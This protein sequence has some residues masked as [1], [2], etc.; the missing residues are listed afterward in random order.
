MAK[1]FTNL[2]TANAVDTAKAIAGGHVSALEVCDAAIDRIEQRNDAV[3]A[4]I[5]QDF[6][7]ARENAKMLDKTRDAG[8]QRPLLGVPMT[9]KESIDVEGLP[10]SWGFPAAA[11]NVAERD[12]IAALR[13]KSAGAIILG[14][15]NVPVALA[16]W[17]S[18]SPVYGR[19]VNPYD[20]VRSPGGSSGGAAAALATG[21]VPLEVGSDIGGS[22][23]IPAHFC[24][25]FGHKTTYGIIPMKGH[26]YPGADALPPELSVLGPLARS[27]GD[28]AIALDVLAG[29]P[30]T[31][32][33]TLALP[34]APQK[35]LGG[36]RVLV[37]DAH[38]A[39]ET[40]LSISKPL[41][42]LAENL[43]HAGVSI[44]RDV[45]G[46]P[47]IAA[48]HSSYRHMLL[49]IITRDMP[50]GTPVDAHGWMDLKDQ[51][52]RCARQWNEVFKHV[53]VVLTPPFGLAA[54]PHDDNPD[55]GAR[56]LVINGKEEPYGTQVAWPGL[57]TFPGLP[58]TVAPI[59]YSD[60]GLPV[61]VQI[62]GASYND[63]TT[64]EFASLLE[65]EGLSL[66]PV[67]TGG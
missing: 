57:V 64:I 27:A 26:E 20:P 32:P 18:D 22:I 7:R 6:E 1:G 53:D 9:V 40:D 65:R 42:L 14:K 38:P 33:Y 31:S 19:T 36:Y 3:N 55:W 25:V 67:Y 49:S 43:E 61:G 29:L 17:Q 66:S 45:D 59:G 51:Q 60:E 48:A 13:L 24:G 34:V 5:I 39:I 35:S 54:F 30:D 50:G 28:L 21:M 56:R 15:T 2:D 47:D 23:R 52:M 44:V 12:S 62:V 58:A 16:D 37:L 10:S 63:H 11:S 4:I 41:N 8:D 46:M